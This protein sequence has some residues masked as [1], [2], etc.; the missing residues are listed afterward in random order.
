MKSLTNGSGP[1]YCPADKWLFH[2]STDGVD[3]VHHACVPARRDHT[4]LA[5]YARTDDSIR[6]GGLWWMDNTDSFVDP[7]RKVEKEMGSPFFLV[8]YMASGIFG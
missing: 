2:S 7:L 4:L 8:L 6:S 3:Q 1:S 5:E